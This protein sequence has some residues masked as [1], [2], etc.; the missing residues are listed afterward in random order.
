MY[1][2]SAIDKRLCPHRC[3][4]RCSVGPS[5]RPI[6]TRCCFTMT[7]MVQVCSNGHWARVFNT[8]IRADEID[9]ISSAVRGTALIRD[10][11]PPLRTTAGP[12]E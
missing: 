10:S 7:D 12:W 9:G 8:N 11:P 3:S 2:T 1:K 6:C 5:I 4:D